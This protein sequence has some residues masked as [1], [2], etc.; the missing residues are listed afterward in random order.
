MSLAV[1]EA[2]SSMG[3]ACAIDNYNRGGGKIVHLPGNCS[4][5]APWVES[6][7]VD[8]VHWLCPG[9]KARIAFD[10]SHQPRRSLDLWDGGDWPDSYSDVRDIWVSHSYTVDKIHPSPEGNLTSDR[11]ML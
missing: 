1:Q 2:D 7:A 6:I 10:L 3:V 5:I 8:A 9:P 4:E 11:M